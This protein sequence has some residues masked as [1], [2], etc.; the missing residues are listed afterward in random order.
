MGCGA[1]NSYTSPVD[2][3]CQTESLEEGTVLFTLSATG[4]PSSILY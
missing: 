2:S 4:T 1:Y 3:L